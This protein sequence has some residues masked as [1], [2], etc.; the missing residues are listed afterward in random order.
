MVLGVVSQFPFPKNQDQIWTGDIQIS[1]PQRYKVPY[2]YNGW[3]AEDL[4]THNFKLEEL[5]KLDG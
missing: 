2:E 4:L 5:E 1:F 3:L